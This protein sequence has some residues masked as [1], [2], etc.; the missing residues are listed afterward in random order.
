MNGLSSA[1][2]TFAAPVLAG[3]LFRQAWIVRGNAPGRLSG[4]SR[5]LLLVHAFV[6]G[7][8]SGLFSLWVLN[9]GDSRLIALPVIGGLLHIGGALLALLGAR[10]M[11]MP[12]S[13]RGS[14]MMSGMVSN[15]GMIGS[16]LAFYFFGEAGYAL[17]AFF[18]IFEQPIY[19]LIGYPVTSAMGN[20][21]KVTVTEGLRQIV[22]EPT[23]YMPILGL[24]AGLVLNLAGVGRPASIGTINA[25]LIPAVT[26]NLAFSIGITLRVGAIREHIRPCL[27]MAAVK[28]AAL[29]LLIAGLA[30][31]A[32]LDRLDGGLPF[33]VALLMSFMP[34]GVNA[35][36]ATTLFRL[37]EEMAV[38]VW[39]S[40]NLLLLPVL[41]LYAPLV[42]MH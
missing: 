20:G 23:I 7:P 12:A 41:L 28:F 22:T 31:L 38:A 3:F 19:F 21:R 17:G 24:A 26:I 40:N 14:F 10:I 39:L 37:D 4:L 18:R 15:I 11:R 33:R 1:L 25:A 36:I 29:P 2:L 35:L 42:A 6:L 5:W 27:V 16:I 9:L 30:K 13:Q 8:V 32:G 34:V